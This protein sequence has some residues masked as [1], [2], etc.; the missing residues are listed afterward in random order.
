MGKGSKKMEK[1]ADVFLG[2]HLGTKIMGVSGYL[3]F[4]FEGL[5]NRL[6]NHYAFS[7]T[8]QFLYLASKSFSNLRN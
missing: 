5:A 6:K 2:G 1:F 8:M 3:T 4:F 7:L